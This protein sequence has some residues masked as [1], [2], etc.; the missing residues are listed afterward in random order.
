MILADW[1]RQRT[2]T[3][4]AELSARIQQ[5]LGER[6]N[7]DASAAPDLCIAAAE[8]LL[9]ELL[10]RP[11]AGRESALDLLTVDALVTYAFEA[12][13]EH[14]DSLLHHAEHAM[15]SLAAAARE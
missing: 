11:S 2:P 5:T 13:S 7:A 10:A 4:P 9:R 15:G 6:C 14:P 1:L 3:P 12:A 8:S